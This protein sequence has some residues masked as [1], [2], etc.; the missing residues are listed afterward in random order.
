MRRSLTIAT[1]AVVGVFAV[2]AGGT[3]V[4]A[5]R[6]NAATARALD[7]LESSPSG[8]AE[9]RPSAVSPEQFDALPSPVRRYFEFA[10]APRQRMIERAHLRQHGVMRA[11]AGAAWKRFTAVEHFSTHPVG[12][13]WD[14]TMEMIPLLPVRIRDGYADG[15]GASAASLGG[16][17][18]I[19]KIGG[20]PEVASSSLLRYLAE[21]AWL[22]TA[23]LP[24]SGVR[25]TGIDR[26]HA[27]ATLTDRGVTVSMDVTFGDRGEIVRIAAIRYRDMHG[28]PV[29]TPWSA[30]FEDYTRIEGM[31]I[32]LSGQ[33]EWGPPEGSLAVW[34]AR[35]TSAAF[36]VDSSR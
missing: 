34:R 20:T 7:R 27:S 6:W 16:L 3:A 12:F 30:S 18:P 23:L 28:T 8:D 33:V 26:D 19:A 15:A 29:L 13:V 9:R 25:W 17:I 31:M 5:L 21:S 4:G 24:Q 36:E 32:P 35:V 22:P 14:A 10:L 2:F 1:S 11:E